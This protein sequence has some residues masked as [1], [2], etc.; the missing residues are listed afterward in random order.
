MA[1]NTLCN[2]SIAV[3]RLW[4]DIFVMKTVFCP[5]YMQDHEKL[6]HYQCVYF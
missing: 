2:S 6:S 5:K 3:V 4:A 1:L